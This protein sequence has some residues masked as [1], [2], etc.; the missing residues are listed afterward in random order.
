MLS[1]NEMGVF[2]NTLAR[3]EQEVDEGV[4]TRGAQICIVHAGAPV[5]S[6]AVGD[7]GT[8]PMTPG[9]VFKVATYHTS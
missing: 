6:L 9:S 4:F 5:L 2:P 8:G 7:A 3:L 1:E